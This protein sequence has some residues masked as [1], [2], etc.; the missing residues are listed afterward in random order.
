VRPLEGTR[1]AQYVQAQEGSAI[2]LIEVVLEDCWVHKRLCIQ[3]E[4]LNLGQLECTARKAVQYSTDISVQSK[5]NLDFCFVRLN[6][7]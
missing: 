2:P 7:K 6:V 1:T 4:V 3:R 5:S